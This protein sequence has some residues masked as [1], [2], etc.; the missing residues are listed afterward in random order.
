[1]VA[2]AH[3]LVPFI[4]TISNELGITPRQVRA[5]MELLAEGATVPFIS[6]Y[7]KEATESL[8]E[9]AVMAIRDRSQQLE[10][11]QKRRQAILKSLQERELLTEDLANQITSAE[12]LARLEDIYLPFRPKRRTK[13][14]MAREKG[15]EPLADWI[16][17]EAK[18][19][20]GETS[21]HSPGDYCWQ[22]LDVAAGADADH[23]CFG[24]ADG[25]HAA[26]LLCAAA[27]RTF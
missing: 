24:L 2:P 4:Q 26:A 10:D 19:P 6:R 16:M 5:T 12:T 21:N 9:V 11:L 22:R 23:V 13:A 20:S 27:F 17:E 18:L 3:S 14:M 25:C 1:M 8:D 7:R 15:L